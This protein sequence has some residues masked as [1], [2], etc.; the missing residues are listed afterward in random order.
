MYTRRNKIE[1]FIYKLRLIVYMV[2]YTKKAPS[3]YLTESD[4]KKVF[5]GIIPQEEF[6]TILSHKRKQLIKEIENYKDKIIGKSLTQAQ[7]EYLKKKRDPL[8]PEYLNA[9]DLA[10]IKQYYTQHTSRTKGIQ[11][12]MV[13][14]MAELGLRVQEVCDL[15]A[16]AV[17]EELGEV[18]I[19]GKGERIQGE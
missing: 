10:L 15:E 3:D 1:R 8:K 19:F 13:K 6:L 4:L 11:Y 14:L 17:D 18:S 12:A 9:E 5:I 7:L 16:D 2:D